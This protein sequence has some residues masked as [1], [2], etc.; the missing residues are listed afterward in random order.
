[1]GSPA[2]KPKVIIICGPTGVGKTAVGIQL[3]EKL[4]G[5]I[6][7]ADSMQIYRYM[8]IGT[9]KPTADEQ[10]RIPHHMIDIVDPDENFDAVRFA[11]MARDKV[12]QLHQ[13]GVMPLVVGGTGLYI[14]ALLQGLFQSNPV[15]P[16]TRERLMKEAAENGSGILYD[17][18]KRVDPDT[19]D[20]L[21]PN[22]SYRI[23]RALETIESTGRSISEHQ[24]E[25]GFSDEPFNAL[26]IYLRIDRQKLYERIDKRVDMMIEEGLVDEVKKLLAMSYSADL[27]SMQS[28]GYRH[29]VEFLAEQLPWDECVRTLKRDT[30][31]FAKRQFTWF[32]ADRQIQWYEPDQLNEIVRL[33]EG[34][35]D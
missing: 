1:M 23:I 15:D 28:I 6:I 16:K 29:M 9:A 5:E 19:A 35:L 18:L 27:K 31:R 4:D 25:H 30:R 26:K 22:D 20:R 14:K 11:E 13:R 24:Q 12:M 32:G 33:V 21:H 10:S 34:F 7:S 8:D 2:N 3:A 17:R